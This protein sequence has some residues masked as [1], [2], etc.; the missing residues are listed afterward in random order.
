MSDSGVVAQVLNSYDYSI[1]SH[2]KVVN[3]S[4]FVSNFDRNDVKKIIPATS[5]TFYFM[6]GLLDQSFGLW[7]FFDGT[8]G[9]VFI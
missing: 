5:R 2:A 3:F 1:F 9:S 4:L 6:T 8:A 7:I